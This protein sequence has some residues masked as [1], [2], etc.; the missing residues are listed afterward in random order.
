MR[1][2]ILIHQPCRTNSSPHNKVSPRTR[3]RPYLSILG[4]IQVCEHRYV[5]IH[6]VLLVLTS[7]SA[8]FLYQN[9]RQA[10]HILEHEEHAVSVVETSVKCD[11]RDFPQFLQEELL[12]LDSLKADPPELTAQIK[13]ANALKRYYTCKYVWL[14]VLY[15]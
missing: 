1:T 14:R 8:N 9:Y 6:N 11:R 4:L 10:L 12:Y 13:Y 15:G 7:L 5:A 2:T 3:H